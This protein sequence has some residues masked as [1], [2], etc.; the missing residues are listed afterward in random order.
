CPDFTY[1]VGSLSN[2]TARIVS[3]GY[4]PSGN[5]QVR[6]YAIQQTASESGPA[7]GEFVITRSQADYDTSLYPFTVYYTLSGT[8]INGVDYETLPGSVTIPAGASF[9]TVTVT[10]IDAA[11]FEETK[12]VIL[13]L[14]NGPYDILPPSNA[15]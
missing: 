4:L 8:A 2:A 1:T 9:A 15:T 7:R 3:D 11:V 10:P 12:T 13:A 5:W 6:A 14:K